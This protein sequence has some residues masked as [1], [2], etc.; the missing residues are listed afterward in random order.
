LDKFVKIASALGTLPPDS[1]GFR[2]LGSAPDSCLLFLY[3]IL[4][5]LTN[6]AS[7]SIQTLHFLLVGA[8][9]YYLPRAQ[10]TL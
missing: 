8:Q 9:K 4:Q 10:G 2:R 1:F 5:L 3:S 7:F 6:C